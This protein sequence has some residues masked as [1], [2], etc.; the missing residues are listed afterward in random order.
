M[1]GVILSINPQANLIDLSHAIPP[2]SVKDAA[3]LLKFCYRYFP[4]GTVHVA[5]VD[6]GVG[7]AR[8]ALIAKNAHAFFL[9]PDNGLLTS[10]LAED[11]AMEVREIENLEY[12]L[13]PSGSTFDGRDIFAPAAA[14]LT[15]YRA[16]ESFGNLVRDCV[17]IPIPIPKW[18]GKAMIGE[19]IHIDR[20]GNLISNITLEH[21]RKFQE[22]TKRTNPLISIMHHSIKG[23]VK[24][25]QEGDPQILGALINSSGQL[26]LFLKES[27]AASAFQLSL[28]EVIKLI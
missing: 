3:Y 19:I 6:P 1:K 14:W 11:T 17:I 23:F 28:N 13:I 5:V 15:R 9:A 8:R 7:T 25:Y 27:S 26:E 4:K 2:H 24:N 21:L 16:L 18:E 22:V 12:S 10:I 20:F